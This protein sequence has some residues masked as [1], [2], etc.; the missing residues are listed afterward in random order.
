M[1]K[2]EHVGIINAVVLEQHLSTPDLFIAWYKEGKL[3]TACTPGR[4]EGSEENITVIPAALQ[5]DTV[6]PQQLFLISEPMPRLASSPP[7]SQRQYTVNWVNAAV[8]IF[9]KSAGC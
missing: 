6:T 3:T 1:L 4:T 7:A 5:H 9:L 2:D 8:L